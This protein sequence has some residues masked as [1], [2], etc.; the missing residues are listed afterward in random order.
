VQV[1]TLSGEVVS[2]VVTAESDSTVTLVDS[3]GKGFTI[4]RED[5]DELQTSPQSVMPEELNKE[6]TA[7]QMRH[8]IAYVTNRRALPAK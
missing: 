4:S 8:L 3:Q 1:V 5:I 6:I 7:D 2:G